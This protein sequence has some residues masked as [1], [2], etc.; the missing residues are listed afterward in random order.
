MSLNFFKNKSRR[1]RRKRR[2]DFRDF[3]LKKIR[4][5]EGGQSGYE[6]FVENAKRAEG[7]EQLLLFILQRQINSI[8]T[9]R[10]TNAAARCRVDKV[11]SAVGSSKRST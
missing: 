10:P 4:V 5:I 2:C 9:F 11:T 6:T 7:A 3:Q 8:R 1:I